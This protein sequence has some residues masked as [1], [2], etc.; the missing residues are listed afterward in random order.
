[1]LKYFYDCCP[2]T[3]FASP[4][5]ENKQPEQVFTRSF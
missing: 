4:V 2:E 3:S 5:Q 1:M